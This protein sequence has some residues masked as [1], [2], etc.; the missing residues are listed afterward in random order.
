MT[1]H[2]LHFFPVLVFFCF[3]DA[4]KVN[5]NA[6]LIFSNFQKTGNKHLNPFEHCFYAVGA[7][8]SLRCRPSPGSHCHTSVECRSSAPID[9]EAHNP[10][11]KVQRA[12]RLWFLLLLKQATA[13][14]RERER[15][16]LRHKTTSARFTPTP[17][18]LE[19][20]VRDSKVSNESVSTSGGFQLQ[21]QIRL[22]HQNI[23]RPNLPSPSHHIAGTD[24]KE[25]AI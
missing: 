5:R 12:P 16:I 17:Q 13:R 22:R 6:K 24:K 11:F 2:E 8:C 18:L 10:T 7:E 1:L 3:L 25:S 23:S 9:L 20:P 4:F 15:A 14:E 21:T 19:T